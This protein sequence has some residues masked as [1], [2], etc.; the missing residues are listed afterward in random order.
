MYE[1]IESQSASETC[2]FHEDGHACSLRGCSLGCSGTPCRPYSRQRAKRYAEGS[3]KTHAD[4]YLTEEVLLDWLAAA[5]PES[6]FFENVE[7]WD[8]PEV[9]GG[10]TTPL[11]RHA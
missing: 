2:L 9:K 1:T 5:A 6:G 10:S 8:M 11:A 7:G 4:A 3:V